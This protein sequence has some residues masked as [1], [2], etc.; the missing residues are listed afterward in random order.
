MKTLTPHRNNKGFTLI[1]L[2]TVIAIIGILAAIAIPNLMSYKSRGSDAA[3][4]ADLK[5]AITAA[6]VECADTGFCPHNVGEI[7]NLA[8]TDG[9][10]L[11]NAAGDWV[12]D[13][14]IKIK[15]QASG[16]S[17]YYIMDVAG[18]LSIFTN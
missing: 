11:S 4:K 7:D 15:A 5:N 17:N 1:E 3:A 2:L 16:S 10:V 8:V 12:N 9:V 6:L 14:D 18:N 13:A